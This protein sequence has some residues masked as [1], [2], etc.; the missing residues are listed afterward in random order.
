MVTIMLVG[1]NLH[2]WVSQFIVYAPRIT[3]I[4]DM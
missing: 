3:H 2:M 1:L 4:G